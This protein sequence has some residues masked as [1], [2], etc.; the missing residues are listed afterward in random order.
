MQLDNWAGKI[1]WVG[2][3]TEGDRQIDKQTDRQTNRQTD[4]KTLRH[5]DIQTAG[6]K[7]DWSTH[8]EDAQSDRVKEIPKVEQRETRLENE[9][10]RNQGR[11]KGKNSEKRKEIVLNKM[12]HRSTL[13]K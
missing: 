8:L 7:M 6:K 5:T 9:T 12:S 2:R 4:R 13:L 1:D 11:R 3:E 10:E